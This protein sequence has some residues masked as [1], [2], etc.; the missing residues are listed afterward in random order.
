[1][2]RTCRNEKAAP[3]RRVQRAAATTNRPEFYASPHVL[4]RPYCRRLPP[5]PAASAPQRARVMSPRPAA[6]SEGATLGLLILL[7]SGQTNSLP[8][9]QAREGR[10]LAERWLRQLVEARHASEAA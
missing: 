4:S 5:T 10:I 3:D 2:M 8:A 9:R 7:L 1:M 6:S